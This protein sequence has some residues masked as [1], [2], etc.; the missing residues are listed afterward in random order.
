MRLGTAIVA[1]AAPN[2]LRRKRILAGAITGGVGQLVASPTDVV[3]IRIQ[4]DGRLKLQGGEPRY[5]GAADA[6]RRIFA[7][8]GMRG[9]KAAM[10]LA[11]CGNAARP[12]EAD[13]RA[14]TGRAPS[15]AEAS[16]LLLAAA[17][18]A[19]SAASGRR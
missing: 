9:E 14:T 18:Q 2:L 5:T 10:H 13:P 1:I 16:A 17:P 12:A 11:P 3:K 19:C 6:F 7:E 8:E 15:R 4:A